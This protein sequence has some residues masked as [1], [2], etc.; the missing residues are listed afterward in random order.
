MTSPISRI[1]RARNWCCC[2]LTVSAS[3]RLPTIPA[4]SGICRS[5][6]RAPSP[7]QRRARLRPPEDGVSRLRDRTVDHWSPQIG[8]V[9]ALT[10][11]GSVQAANRCGP[12]RQLLV[13]K[14]AAIISVESDIQLF[15]DAPKLGVGDVDGNGLSDIVATRV[16]R[17]AF[18]C[19]WTRR[20]RATEPGD[21]TNVYQQ[22]SITAAAREALCPRPRHRR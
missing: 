20:F 2:A 6:D 17:S 22:S 7:L 1:R 10:A 15:L 16:T 18:F 21:P 19:A 13:A 8:A 3:C 12:P 4:R 11:D 5:P 14:P 9:T